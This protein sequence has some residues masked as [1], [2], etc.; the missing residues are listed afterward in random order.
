MS[1][2]K[3]EVIGRLDAMFPRDKDMHRVCRTPM[4]LIVKCKYGCKFSLWYNENKKQEGTDI[5]FFRNVNMNHNF[6][7]HLARKIK[8]SEN[9]V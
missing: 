6:T 8:K 1:H 4:Y 3:S 9:E 2:F 5:K 7:L